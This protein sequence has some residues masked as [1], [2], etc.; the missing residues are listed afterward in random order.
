MK[1]VMRKIIISLV[2][3]SMCSC[4]QKENSYATNEEIEIKG[5]ISTKKVTENG[6]EREINVLIPDEPIIVDNKTVKEIEIDY[7]KSLKDDYDITIKGI[8]KGEALLDGNDFSLSVDDVEDVASHTNTY[9]HDD[10]SMTIPSSI[11]KLCSIE[12]IE[13]G[14]IVYSRSNK[15]YGGKV[16]TIESLTKE[17]FNIMKKDETKYIERITSNHDKTIVIEFPTTGQE[18]SDEFIDEYEAIGNSVNQIKNN[19]KQK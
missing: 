15:E 8:I 3:L 2:L 13:K 5:T 4:A 9:H 12:K 18:Y 19:I 11:I 16:F 6:V 7:D 14:F 17:E 10:F 1:S